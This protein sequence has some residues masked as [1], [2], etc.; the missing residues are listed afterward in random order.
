M[1]LLL[2]SKSTCLEKFWF[3]RYAPKF[4][5]PIRLQNYSIISISGRNIYLIEYL[6][7]GT[8][9]AKAAAETTT[10]GSIWPGVPS[11]ARLKLA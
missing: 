8:H 11:L 10:F 7:G 5:L 9:Q 2:S 4:S 3:K 1:V 6:D